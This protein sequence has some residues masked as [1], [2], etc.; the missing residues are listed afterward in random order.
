MTTKL[1]A[2]AKARFATREDFT[3]LSSR[4]L[5]MDS[6][7]AKL[8]TNSDAFMDWG[9]TKLVKLL[10]YQAIA[11]LRNLSLAQNLHLYKCM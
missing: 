10:K 7:I 1:R 4:L 9:F 3:S 6:L 2:S 11:K 5:T 8:A